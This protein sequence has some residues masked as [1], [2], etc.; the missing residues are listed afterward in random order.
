MKDLA[1]NFGSVACRG[2]D[3]VDLFTMPCAR[4]TGTM[5]VGYAVILAITMVFGG[6]ATTR[7]QA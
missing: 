5:M 2:I 3:S 4:T 6:L 1:F 7:V